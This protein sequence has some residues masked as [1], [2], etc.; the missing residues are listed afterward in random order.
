MNEEYDSLVP[1]R[2][3]FKTPVQPKWEL[4]WP[5]FDSREHDDDWSSSTEHLT[6]G[7]P[8]KFRNRHHHM[9]E[10]GDFDMKL[11]FSIRKSD[12]SALYRSQR[13]GKLLKRVQPT[14]F[15]YLKRHWL[16]DDRWQV[17]PLQTKLSLWH[18]FENR[19]P[20]TSHLFYL[21]VE[22]NRMISFGKVTGVDGRVLVC[23]IVEERNESPVGLSRLQGRWQGC[24]FLYV[25]GTMFVNFYIKHHR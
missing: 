1:P 14:A 25:F 22:R 15:L 16:Y 7:E 9:A 17:T 20:S 3:T 19:E 4:W 6:S 10:A 11:R 12:G 21:R 24:Q 8:L 23:M 18:I 5:K 13:E 2:D